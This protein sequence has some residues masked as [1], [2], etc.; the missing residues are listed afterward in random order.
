MVVGINKKK[1]NEQTD[2]RTKIGSANFITKILTA[3]SQA[4]FGL[5]G[6]SGN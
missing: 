4:P 5:P 3:A 2:R 1:T 6:A